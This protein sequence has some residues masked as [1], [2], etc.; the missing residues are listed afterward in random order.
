MVDFTILFETLR[1]AVAKVIH[2]AMHNEPTIDWLLK[3]QNKV[4]HFFHQMALK[5][6]L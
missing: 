3:N 6:E 2:K 1:T 4:E 5:G